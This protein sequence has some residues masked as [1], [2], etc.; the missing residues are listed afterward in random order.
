MHNP[1]EFVVNEFT[2]HYHFLSNF[3]PV[4]ITYKGNTFTTVEAAFQ[5]QKCFCPE[6]KAAF[7]NVAPGVA[8]KMGR[9]VEMRKDWD[10][11][12]DD[13]MYELVKLKF[14][15]P[16]LRDTLVRTSGLRLVEG[17]RWGDK[18]WGVDIASGEGQNRLGEILMRVR[19]ELEME[20]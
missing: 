7:E 3:Y 16:Y 12:K 13:Y 6:A 20:L 5:A 4:E 17:N 1:I 14:S 8:K 9:A 10:L 11:V 19:D 15:V 18:Y 2:G